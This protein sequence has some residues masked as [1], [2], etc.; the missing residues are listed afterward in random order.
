MPKKPIPPASTPTNRLADY[1]LLMHHR[2]S[3]EW[4]QEVDISRREFIALKNHL[5]TVRGSA[6]EATN[7]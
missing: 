3:G 4:I 5:A 6:G 7:A 2:R 1:V